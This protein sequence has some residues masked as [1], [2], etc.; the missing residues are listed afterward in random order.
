MN[1]A[2]VKTNNV[3]T[4]RAMMEAPISLPPPPPPVCV[5]TSL[6]SRQLRR[7]QCLKFCPHALSPCKV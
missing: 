6:D 5:V 2:T 7:G 4:L 1:H 3:V